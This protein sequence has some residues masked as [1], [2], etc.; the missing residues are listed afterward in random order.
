MIPL[1]VSWWSNQNCSAI[2]LNINNLI[3][4]KDKWAEADELLKK[5]TK[6]SPS[7]IEKITNIYITTIEELKLLEAISE[8]IEEIYFL[9]ILEFIFTAYKKRIYWHYHTF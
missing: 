2:R 4:N 1:I 6:D 9:V 7:Y 5:L 8:D 3:H